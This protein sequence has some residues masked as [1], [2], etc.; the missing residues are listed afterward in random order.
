[1]GLQRRRARGA[2]FITSGIGWRQRRW[3]RR[4]TPRA[5]PGV[6]AAFLRVHKRSKHGQELPACLPPR[7]PCGEPLPLACRRAQAC[8]VGATDHEVPPEFVRALSCSVCATAHPAAVAPPQGLTSSPLCSRCSFAE[9]CVNT[10]L[11]SRADSHPSMRAVRL[12]QLLL[13]AAAVAGAAAAT[14]HRTP[15]TLPHCKRA[16]WRCRACQEC[17]RGFY[18]SRGACR[19]C[20]GDDLPNCARCTACRY[21]ADCVAGRRCTEC[22]A[23]TSQRYGRGP[24]QP[25]DLANCARCESCPNGI[26]CVGGR[27]CTACSPGFDLTGGACVPG[28]VNGIQGPCGNAN[29]FCPLA[30]DGACRSYPGGVP[31]Y[32]VSRASKSPQPAA[33]GRAR[34]TT[35]QR[36]RWRLERSSTFAAPPSL[37]AVRDR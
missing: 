12:T 22:A 4:R 28:S 23:G 13:V 26:D 25:C 3:R 19:P 16:D 14:E 2:I 1:M 8:C 6:S 15:C 21:G 27:R 36:F 33:A 32:D 7:P 37:H 24:C 34:S 9:A 11:A 10:H 18:A 31:C 17:H 5:P 29:L 30:S 20:S 35:G